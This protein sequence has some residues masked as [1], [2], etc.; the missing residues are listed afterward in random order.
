[1]AIRSADPEP[2]VSLVSAREGRAT[3]INVY[4]SGAVDEF[5]RFYPAWRSVSPEA[6]V[7]TAPATAPLTGP[8]PREQPALTVVEAAKLLGTG[9]ERVRVLLRSG[10]LEGFKRGGTWYVPTDAL[11]EFQASRRQ[12]TPPPA[13][14]QEQVATY[15]QAYYAQKKRDPEWLERRRAQA[16]EAMRRKRERERQA[17]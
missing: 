5:F 9:P 6:L 2:V 8:V 13:A 10:H 7:F 4:P 16:R 11:A 17:S 12:Q 1:L 15:H 14:S 3:L